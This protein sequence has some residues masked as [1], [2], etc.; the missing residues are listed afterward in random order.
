MINK[1]TKLWQQ[2]KLR[3]LKSKLLDQK[4]EMLFE[5]SN[6]YVCFDC[7]TTGLNPKQDQI[8]TLSAIKIIENKIHTSESLN[9][10]IKQKHSISEESIVIH[11]IRNVDVQNDQNTYDDEIKAMQSFLSFIRGATLVGYYV[12]F[13]IAMVNKTIES[14]IGIKLPNPKIEVADLFYEHKRNQFKRSCID[15]NIDLSFQTILSELNIPN[16]GQHD[17]YSDA[18]MTALIFVKL[19]QIK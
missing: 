2:T 7:E 14:M 13:D 4:Y 10:T 18:L 12:D 19:N 11:H 5:T 8:I 17:A 6:T 15:P 16:L 9:L 3:R 1:L